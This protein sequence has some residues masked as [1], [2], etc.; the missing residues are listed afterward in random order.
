MLKTAKQ[1]A[2]E[3]E[4]ILLTAFATLETAV[5]AMKLGAYDYLT[6]PF[7]VDEINV[8]IEW[9]ALEKKKL[10]SEQPGAARAAAG[11]LPPRSHR[12][13]IAGHAAHLR[14]GQEGGARQD[15]GAHLRR[16]GHRQGAGGPGAAHLGRRPRGR[17]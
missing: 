2:S 12:R 5:A 10:H 1:H 3:P 13:Q 15:L 11:T 4:V 9:R 6:K 7:K 8:V 14:A 16:I 17:S